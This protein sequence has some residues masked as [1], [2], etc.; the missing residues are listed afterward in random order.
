[1]GLLVNVY[2]TRKDGCTGNWLSDRAD[3]LCLVNLPGPFEPSS[4]APAAWLDLGCVRGTAKIIPAAF[5][6][7]NYCY[8]AG[9]WMMGGNYAAT[10]DS[11][12]TAAVEA[13]TD[14]PF[15][16]AVAIHDRYE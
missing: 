14:L 2:R 11:R 7:K 6:G 3:Q 8:P 5:D 1:M 9:W 13:I 10:S 12:F 15:Y 4:D 16:G